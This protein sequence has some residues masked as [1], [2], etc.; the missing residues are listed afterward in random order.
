MMMTPMTP[1]PA[2]PR[3]CALHHVEQ[4]A[5]NPQRGEDPATEY[6]AHLRRR[7]YKPL[8]VPWPVLAPPL[9]ECLDEDDEVVN[10]RGEGQGPDKPVP[11]GNVRRG[12][13]CARD[14]H[15]CDERG[16]HEHLRLARLRRLE[17]GD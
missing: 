7:R 2:A 15:A 3:P 6:H 10:D 12:G 13:R 16:T 14:D 5:Y 4:R 8:N 9:P 1:K 17:N 11:Q